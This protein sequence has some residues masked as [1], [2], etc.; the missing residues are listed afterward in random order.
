[1]K[2]TERVAELVE[3][4]D[5]PA[6]TITSC[7]WWLTSISANYPKVDSGMRVFVK[8]VWY[9]LYFFKMARDFECLAPEGVAAVSLILRFLWVSKLKTRIFKFLSITDRDPLKSKG[10]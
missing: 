8:N 10:L 2:G 3:S 9:R 6:N 5:L 4:A 7:M 1:M